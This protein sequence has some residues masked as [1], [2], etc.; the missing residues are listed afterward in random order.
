MGKKNR[1][2]NWRRIRSGKKKKK[3]NRERRKEETK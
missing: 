3:K 2:G 1:E